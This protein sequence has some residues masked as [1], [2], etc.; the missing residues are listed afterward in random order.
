MIQIALNA[1]LEEAILIHEA[2]VFSICRRI[3]GSVDASWDAFQETFLAMTRQWETL[4]HDRDLK[5]WLAET[6]RRCSLTVLRKQRKHRASDLSND[7]IRETIFDESDVD[8][9]AIRRE[10][11]QIMSEEFAKLRP[12]E[13]ELLSMCV[14]E[15]ISHRHAAKTLECSPGSIHAKVKSAREELNA[16]MKKRGVAYSFL[17]LGFLLQNEASASHPGRVVT[18]SRARSKGAGFKL[19][20]PAINLQTLCLCAAVLFSIGSII[21]VSQG[22]ISAEN[23]VIEQTVSTT[24]SSIADELGLE[25][26]VCPL[27]E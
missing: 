6:A 18:K 12:Q 20:L 1:E 8:G 14:V 9:L 17:L 19:D 23:Y 25:E 22:S 2:F 16:R 15:G 21:F 3:T 13:R 26:E 5:P 10:L 4:D 11:I 7:E 24:G 27:D